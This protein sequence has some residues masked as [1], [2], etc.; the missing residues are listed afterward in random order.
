MSTYDEFRRKHPWMLRWEC[1]NLAVSE[2]WHR[3]VLRSE[4]EPKEADHADAIREIDELRD[5][6]RHTAIHTLWTN[7]EYDRRYGGFHKVTRCK[8]G[9]CQYEFRQRRDRATGD[10]IHPHD[11]GCP[12]E[13]LEENT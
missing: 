6:L 3:A 1:F 10:E 12:W 5:L 4:G 7:R 11:N 2:W 13:W 9:Q 8:Y